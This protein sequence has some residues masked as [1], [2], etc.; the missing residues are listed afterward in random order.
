MTNLGATT[1]AAAAATAVATVT[2]AVAAAAP[3]YEDIKP[4]DK[5]A[6]TLDGA[7][8]KSNPYSKRK[9]APYNI[10]PPDTSFYRSFS[11]LKGMIAPPFRCTDCYNNNCFTVVYSAHSVYMLLLWESTGL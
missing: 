8:V 10:V 9:Y 6:H 5:S 11:T 1:V 4:E 3:V 7:T 2:A